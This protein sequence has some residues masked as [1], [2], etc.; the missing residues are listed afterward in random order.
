[1]EGANHAVTAAKEQIDAHEIQAG[2]VMLLHTTG[3]LT[4][5]MLSHTDGTLTLL[6]TLT[7]LVLS[8]LTLLVFS[9]T[10]GIL[11]QCWRSLTLLVLSC[12]AGALTLQVLS[13]F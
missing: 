3:A 9:H 13:Y 1:V 7:L 8:H 2:E 12:S 6:L 5:L 10:A 4:L 11:S